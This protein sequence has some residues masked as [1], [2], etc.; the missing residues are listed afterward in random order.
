M[1]FIQDW[2][3]N[4]LVKR[5]FSKNALYNFFYTV[6][7]FQ[8]KVE[9]NVWLLYDFLKFNPIMDLSSIKLQ[10]EKHVAFLK[11]GLKNLPEQLSVSKQ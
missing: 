7:I 3:G 11:R 10:R 6:T 8:I 1:L 4:L 9:E 5:N 2:E